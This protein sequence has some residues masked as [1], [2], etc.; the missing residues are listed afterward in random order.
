MAAATP[1]VDSVV[2]LPDEVTS[3]VRSAFV[4]TVAA[5][6]PILKFVTGVVEVTTNGAVPMATV[7]VNEPVRLKLVPVAAPIAGVTKV[8][9]VD[10]T[11]FPVPVAAVTPV[12][13]FATGKVPL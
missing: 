7:E 13:P 12:P 3:P 9:E 1:E 8:G 6:P 2:A 11:T 4:V 10:N 5:L